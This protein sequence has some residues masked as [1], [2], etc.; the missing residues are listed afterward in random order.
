MS[1]QV[2]PCD[3]SL[4]RAITECYRYEYRTYYKVLFNSPV[5]VLVIISPNSTEAL[6]KL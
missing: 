5:L 4:A 1:V 2:K 3:P 6:T